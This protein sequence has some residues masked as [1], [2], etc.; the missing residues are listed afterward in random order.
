MK[1]RARSGRRHGAGLRGAGLERCFQHGRLFLIEA[2][3]PLFFQLANATR[4]MRHRTPRSNQSNQGTEAAR[5][6]SRPS[7]LP[8]FPPTDLA[9]S[10]GLGKL[11]CLLGGVAR[12]LGGAERHRM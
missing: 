6:G 4:R 5:S 3:L 1:K 2:C 10:H 11:V 7:I 9:G 8:S 12:G